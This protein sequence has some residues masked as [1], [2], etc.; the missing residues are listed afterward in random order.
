MNDMCI[1]G[2]EH[3]F[4]GSRGRWYDFPASLLGQ[5]PVRCR[6]CQHRFFVPRYHNGSSRDVHRLWKHYVLCSGFFLLI[7]IYSYALMKQTSVSHVV[8]K[9]IAPAVDDGAAVAAEAPAQ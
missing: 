9:P 1:D 8:N 5:E 4:A 6:N 2:F 7:G 3:D